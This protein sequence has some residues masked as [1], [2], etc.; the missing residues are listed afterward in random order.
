MNGL[1]L[2]ERGYVLN[3]VPFLVL[4]YLMLNSFGRL[5]QEDGMVSA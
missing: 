5:I 4:W 2:Y 1:R 3:A